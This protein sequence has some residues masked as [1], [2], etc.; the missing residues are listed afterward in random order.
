M[1]KAVFRL[2]L[3]VVILLSTAAAHGDAEEAPFSVALRPGVTF[4]VGKDAEFF[5]LGGAAAIHGAYRFPSRRLLFAAGDLAYDL[6]T[7]PF[8]TTLSVLSLGLG[9]GVTYDVLPRLN[10]RGSL[11]AGGYL[12]FMNDRSGPVSANPL[13]SAA[14]GGF[15]RVVPRL[16][17]G[18]DVEYRQLFGFLSGVS[19]SLAA[20]HHVGA[21]RTATR[22]TSRRGA[23][24][25]A[26]ASGGFVE[27]RETEFA[28]IFPVFFKY[29]DDH[30]VGRAV[31]ANRTWKKI[32]DIKVTLYVKQYMDNP[33][34]CSAPVELAANEEA[35]IELHALFTE[36]ILD[37]TETTKASAEI[38]VEYTA[39]GERWRDSH[40]ES[41][42][43]Y[44][45]N[46]MQWDDDR[47]AAAFVTAK[48]P[49]VLTFSKNVV[50]LLAESDAAL[51]ENLS[52]AVALHEALALY[53]VRY[54]PDPSTPYEQFSRDARAVDFLQFPRQTILYGAGDCDDLSILWCALLESVNVE[55]AFLT[56]PGHIF[57]AFSLGMAPE[58]AAKLFHRDEDLI[59]RGDDS[60]MPVEVTLVGDGFLTAWE[61]GAAEWREAAAAGQARLLCV[62]EA[63]KEYE[64][65]GLLG[66]GRSVELPGEAA[67]LEAYR[68]ESARIVDREVAPRVSAIQAQMQESGETPQLLNRLGVVYA[69]FGLHE[70]AERE[71]RRALAADRDYVPALV[72]LGNI[73]FLAEDFQAAGYYYE[74]AQE[75]RPGAPQV[76]LALVR[77]RRE[78]G[79]LDAARTAFE[80]L[81]AVDPELAARHADLAREKEGTAR[82]SPA[83]QRKGVV[84]WEE[85]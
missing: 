17:L 60:W 61:T 38:T 32:S 57:I 6:I 43:I 29:Y 72:N 77:V 45:R 37:V 25:G 15:F 26:A 7:L 2:A 4:P 75:S 56:V 79:D 67:L 10:V 24:P 70:Q 83:G 1:S 76:L 35:E 69:R 12:A 81:E 74:R 9:G 11:A 36:K 64:P 63:W 53:G 13:L 19:L 21:E 23:P 49:V 42:R 85:E 46:A 14:V 16:S 51:H 62:E 65:A 47:R 50:G 18:I 48:D 55:T 58:E 82:A 78:M 66:E 27:F 31:L 68:E 84:T 8:G 80:R 22:R 54:I 33:K 71:L 5:D 30:P 59:F 3:G 41:V 40:V 52:I 44:D 20:T 28:G 73:R 34:L 39:G